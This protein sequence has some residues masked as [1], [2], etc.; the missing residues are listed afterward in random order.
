VDATSPGFG[1]RTP[2]IAHFRP[3]P[4]ETIGKNRLVV[5]PY[6]G[7]GLDEGIAYALV[8]TDR[9]RAA[10]G[11]AV[12]ADGDFAAMTAGNAPAAYAPLF[13]YLAT[14]SD[15]VVDA[16][17]FTTQHATSIGAAL[18]KGVF[19]TPAPV[20][21]TIVL[22]STQATYQV[23]TGTYTAPNFQSGMAP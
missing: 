3:D 1:M 18:R 8:V 20:G 14:T 15:H 7:F 16:A 19:G 13:G 4:T 23:W 12:E 21:A 5:R 22:A 17:V 11:S 9:V 2:I 10:D 6:P